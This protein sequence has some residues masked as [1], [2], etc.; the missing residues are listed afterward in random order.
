MNTLEVTGL[1]KA[2]PTFHLDGVSFSLEAGTIMGFIGR[3][4]AGK[5]TTL[6]CLLNLV[7][8]DAG[9]VRFFGL[10]FPQ[11]EL[12]IKAR[13]GFVSGGAD[14]YPKKKLRQITA[15]TRRFYPNWDDVAYHRY[16]ERFHLEEEKTPDALSAG[17]RVKYALAL[18]MSHHAQLLLLDEPTSG[19]D[20]VSREDLLEEFLA[21]A[22]E[23]VSILFSTHITSDLEKCADHITYIQ[24]G[25]ILASCKI[26]DFLEQY[27]LLELKQEQVTEELKP[28][29]VG[30]RRSKNGVTALVRTEDAQRLNLCARPA[31]LESVMVHL[32]KEDEHETTAE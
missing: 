29:L 22:D 13:I 24:K 31:D 32:E 16:L 20:P 11:Q 7:H 8:P 12:E 6:K 2:Y 15:A 26:E 23:G 19:L 5:T 30:V 18:A 27:R 4:G 1:C 9:T 21:L 25:K 10:P 17:M 14:Y 3:N 28:V